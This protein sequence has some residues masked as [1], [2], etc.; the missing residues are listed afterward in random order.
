MDLGIIKKKLKKFWKFIWEGESLESYIAFFLFSIVVL[1]I[2]Y[3]LTLKLLSVTVGVSDLVAVITSSME[4]NSQK[5]FYNYLE[6]FGIGK[7]S[8]MPYKQ[9]LNRGDLIVV[10]KDKNITVGEVIVFEREEGTP[11]IH[12][13][14]KK[15]EVDGTYHYQTKGDANPYSLPF[16]KNISPKQ[17][18]GVAGYKMPYLG[19]PKMLLTQFLIRLS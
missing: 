18:E 17:I 8:S 5:Q 4:H 10:M 9:G 2:I 13:V 3:P 7:N 15:E 6:G 1:A 16:E 12:R 19:V 11:I 14:V